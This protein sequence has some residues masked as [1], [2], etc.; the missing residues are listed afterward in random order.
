MIV[1]ADTR[2]DLFY[3]DLS[4][5]DERTTILPPRRGSISWMCPERLVAEPRPAKEWDVY[6]LGMVIYE[7]RMVVCTWQ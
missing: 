4:Y 7:V 2:L 6:A 5:E 3:S 1:G